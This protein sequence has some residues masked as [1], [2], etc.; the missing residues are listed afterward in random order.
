[1]SNLVYLPSPT[2]ACGNMIDLDKIVTVA[3]AGEGVIIAFNIERPDG[4]V[5]D[6]SPYQ[7]F[8]RGYSVESFAAW[9]KSVKEGKS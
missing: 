4:S 7:L 1:M 6:H 2:G 5:F 9:V 3:W 8:V